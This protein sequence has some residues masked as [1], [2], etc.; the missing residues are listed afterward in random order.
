MALGLP[1]ILFAQQLEKHSLQQNLNCEAIN[2]FAEYEKASYWEPVRIKSVGAD[3]DKHFRF[4]RHD[5]ICG[6]YYKI[7]LV[8][9]ND[10]FH[11]DFPGRKVSNYYATINSLYISKGG[12]PANDLSKTKDDRLQIIFDNCS[13]TARDSYYFKALTDG[14]GLQLYSNFELTLQIEDITYGDNVLYNN[15]VFPITRVGAI[16]KNNVLRDLNKDIYIDYHQTRIP[17]LLV[18]NDGTILVFGHSPRFVSKS[19]DNGRTFVLNSEA[20]A[21]RVLGQSVCYDKLNN[22][23]FSA[24]VQNGKVTKSTDGGNSFENYGTIVNSS[25]FYLQEDLDRLKKEESA[26]P[27]KQRW[28]FRIQDLAG[29]GLGIQLT[30]GVLAM[31]VC[32]KIQKIKAE[33][34][35][36]VIARGGI[37]NGEVKDGYIMKDGYPYRRE[38]DIEYGNLS[39]FADVHIGVNYI[40]YS[41]DY[42]ET[43]IKS[44]PTPSDVILSEFSIAEVEENQIMINSRGGSEAAFAMTRN[45]RRVLVPTNSQ[46]G[47]TRENYTIE[48]WQLEPV[49]DGKLWDPLC[50]AAFM[51]VDYHGHT[52]WLFCN[53]YINGREEYNPRSNLM[54]QVSSDAKH[55]SKV[56]LISPYGRHV[57]GYCS[58]YANNNKI[59]LAYEGSNSNDRG[60]FYVDLSECF[61]E[62]IL[63]TYIMN[64][65]IFK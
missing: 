22:A 47:I 60:I 7:T 48:G 35:D 55:W 18:L 26:N 31:P 9:F 4:L 27:E 3:F 2:G 36:E 49:S 39:M 50:H 24:D 30:N 29:P 43:W 28:Y 56:G 63:T 33:T 14:K 1:Y 25:I 32:S 21:K 16:D 42:G 20:S 41:K 65:E 8:P 15:Y 46:I 62:K 51:R 23:I 53:P 12:E 34:L 38:D 57:E 11:P 13:Y 6:H 61:I 44:V 59:G 64:K 19:T 17:N 40:L 10:D 5:I 52:F 37:W 58:I 45:G 54:L